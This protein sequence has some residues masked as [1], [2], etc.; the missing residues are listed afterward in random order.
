MYTAPFVFPGNQIVRWIFVFILI[1]QAAM[2]G[3]RGPLTLPESSTLPIA[4]VAADASRV[5]SS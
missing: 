1:N 3:Q 2:C 5:H 4:A